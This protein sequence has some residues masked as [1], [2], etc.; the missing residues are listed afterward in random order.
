H[1]DASK[2]RLTV[3]EQQKQARELVAAGVSVRGA[4][5]QL[6]ISKTQVHRY[7]ST[8]GTDTSQRGTP[9][10][11]PKPLELTPDSQEEEREQRRWAATRNL[12]DGIILFDRHKPAFSSRI[13]NTLPFGRFLAFRRRD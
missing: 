12:I 10:P 1:V 8:K 3:A 4:A 2:L 9:K 7:A 6:G 13:P 5:K 11:K